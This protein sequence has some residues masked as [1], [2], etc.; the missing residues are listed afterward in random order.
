MYV[1]SSCLTHIWAVG[2]GLCPQLCDTQPGATW[3]MNS[4]F[5]SSPRTD[6]QVHCYSAMEALIGHANNAEILAEDSDIS[7]IGEGKSN[8]PGAVFE[9][10]G[11]LP[12][13]LSKESLLEYECLR[14]TQRCSTMRK[15]DPSPSLARALL[16]ARPLL[17]LPVLHINASRMVLEN[18]TG[19]CVLGNGRG[20]R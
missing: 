13:V 12:M 10:N 1:S 19:L 6:N 20:D 2:S 14:V 8:T 15:S 16:C 11:C 18:L 3:G 4:E 7:M 9:R 5:V 17:R